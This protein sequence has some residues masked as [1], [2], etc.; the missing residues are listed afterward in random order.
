MGHGFGW[1]FSRLRRPQSCAFSH[2]F[3]PTP[4]SYSSP[5]V[6]VFVT[7]FLHP[8]R[9]PTNLDERPPS[10]CPALFWNPA[11]LVPFPV[12]GWSFSLLAAAVLGCPLSF[13]L[14]TPL[15][16]PCFLELS[17][18]PAKCSFAGCLL[19]VLE[20]SPPFLPP[21]FQ[22]RNHFP[23]VCA[24]PA[25]FTSGNVSA[26]S[27]SPDDFL[28]TPYSNLITRSCRRFF[29]HCFSVFLVRKFS[30]IF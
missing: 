23:G 15:Y 5:H 30:Q 11:T 16:D 2:L 4:Q 22:A 27:A 21:T 13:F 28:V 8:R 24:F 3:F 7:F 14:S 25:L 29:V 6:R 12:S 1:Q 18:P 9:V 20:C 26:P 17:D 19:R 10:P